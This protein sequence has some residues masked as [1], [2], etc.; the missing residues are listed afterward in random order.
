MPSIHFRWIQECSAPNKSCPTCKAKAIIRDIR[1]LYAKKVL[2]CDRSEED[3]LIKVIADERTKNTQLQTSLSTLKLEMSILS[4]KYAALR[5]R[6]TEAQSYIAPIHPTRVKK[7]TYRLALDKNIEMSRDGG[8]RAMAFGRQSQTLLV[9]QKSIIP[10]F[11]GYGVRFV[12]AHTF[13]P[14]AFLRMAPKPIRDLSIDSAE[15]FIA[16][17][18]MERSAYIYSMAGHTPIA[19]ITPS[20]SQVW[21]VRFDESITNRLLVGT[22]Q[23]I[24]Y[25]YDTRS[26]FSYVDEYPTTG[27][28][29]PVSSIVS[30]RSPVFPHGGFLICKLQSIWFYEYSAHFLTQAY[31]L[32]IEG[33]FVTTS[34]DEAS[35]NI[36]I[37]T[38]PSSKYRNARYIV[39][40]L[41]KIGET[42]V[43]RTKCTIFGSTTQQVMSRSTQINI[44]TDSLVAAYVEDA[45][46]LT[47][48]SAESGTK[49]SAFRLEDCILDMC[50]M[51]VNDRT[52]L[53]SASNNR[54]RI[55]QLNSV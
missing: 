45:K 47:T 14:S 38:R 24:T 32:P 39:G 8:C 52:Y 49:V 37:A 25:A 53:A 4:D 46:E 18:A 36:M 34:Y 50:P 16:A 9:S 51:I 22:Q 44:G 29:T 2:S 26:S 3:R 5:S 19:T 55:F 30:V 27:D 12:S 10:L 31:K 13:Q 54:C 15:E 11:P 7:V 6:V 21:A 43:F 33:P 35:G 41:M 48:W 1:V 17:A 42:T 20:D 28:Y 40:T 23:G